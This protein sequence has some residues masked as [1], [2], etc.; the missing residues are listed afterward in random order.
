MPSIPRIN[1]AVGKSGPLMCSSK[2]CS[3]VISLFPNNSTKIPPHNLKELI[4][5]LVELLGNKEITNEQL[6]EE[7]IKGP[8]FPTAGFILGIDGI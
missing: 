7:H 6:F 5:G 3:F 4:S 1:P 2:S 8:D